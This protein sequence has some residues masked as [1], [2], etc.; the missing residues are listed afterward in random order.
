MSFSQ[1]VVWPGTLV[2]KDQVADFEK[3]MMDEFGVRASYIEEVLTAPDRDRNGYPVED[4]GGRNDLF[5][6]VHSDDIPKFSVARL[7]YGMRWIEDV[8]SNGGGNLYPE[9][10]AEYRSW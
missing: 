9:R 8:Y 10:I 2:G 1:V 5:F 4:T 3:F 7:G 6:Y